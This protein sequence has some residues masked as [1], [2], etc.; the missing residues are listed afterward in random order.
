MLCFGFLFTFT[1]SKPTES[2]SGYSEFERDTG[3]SSQTDRQIK[4]AD[5]VMN[6]YFGSWLSYERRLGTLSEALIPWLAMEDK[7]V[8]SL[9]PHSATQL[10]INTRQ[11]TELALLGP[12]QISGSAR[13]S[14]LCGRVAA[15][16]EQGLPPLV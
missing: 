6:V 15:R 11:D 16:I 2:D 10:R 3:A 5:E 8:F 4:R 7:S 1:Q 13:Q 14:L 12:S 9:M